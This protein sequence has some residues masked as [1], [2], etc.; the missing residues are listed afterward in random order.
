MK[1]VSFSVREK[2]TYVS[3][4]LTPANHSQTTRVSRAGV[5]ISCVLLILTLAF[6]GYIIFGVAK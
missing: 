1:S 5:V 4:K 6:L 2:G 3:T